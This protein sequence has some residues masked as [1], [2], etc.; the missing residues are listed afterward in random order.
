MNEVEI[1]EEKEI[2][3]WCRGSK[4]NPQGVLRAL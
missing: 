2:K 4:R 1:I 3:V